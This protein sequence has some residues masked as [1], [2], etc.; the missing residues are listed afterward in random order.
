VNILKGLG[1]E[2]KRRRVLPMTALYI[3]AGWVVVQVASE[4]LPAFNIP[5]NAI[6]YVW[7]A[8]LVG[9]PVAVVFSWR[10]DLTAAGI[11]RTP[12]A[13]ENLKTG[14]R[15][16]KADYGILAALG[17]VMLITVSGVG[18]RLADVQ[19][20]IARAPSTRDIDPNSI[21][22][23]PLENLSPDEDGVYFAS[24]IHDA[25]ITNLSRISALAVTSSTSARRVSP[26]LSVPEI[27]RK[28]GVAKLVEGSVLMEGDR[29]RVIVQLIDAAS[30]LHL[31]AD[32]FERDVTDIMS[33][34][35][36]VARTIADVI[37]VRLT[38]REEKALAQ[39]RPVRPDL[40]RA[41]LKGMYLLRQDTP[42]TDQ[43]AV[44][45]FEEVVREDPDSALAYAGL[46]IGYSNLAHS[47]IPVENAYPKAKTAADFALQLDPELA[48]AHLAVGMYRS[49]YEWDFEG[50]EEAFN[51]AIELNPSLT[52]AHYQLA[53]IYELRGPDWED[54]ALASG[55]RAV[56]LDPL[57][58]F[59]IGGL[60]WQY[61]DACRFE[62]GL[63]VAREAIR[64][65][66]EQPVGWVA[67]GMIY[68]ELGRFDEAID[69]HKKPAEPPWSLFVAMTYAAAGLDD[70]AL[71]FTAA[72]ENVPGA[73]LGLAWIHMNRGDREAAVHWIAAAEKA[74]APWYPWLLGMFHGSETIA[75]DPR[76]QERAAALGLP[77]PRTMGCVA[78]FADA[79][80]FNRVK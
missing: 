43:R 58:A 23:L 62:D 71:E 77:D 52:M 13:G 17:L 66:P 75:D 12:N 5:D 46:A 65:N 51:R 49:M 7:I 34:Q 24:G 68:A 53:W 11:R 69:A 42:E 61:G 47:P 28:L 9:F 50:A 44:E 27:G 18:L 2:L 33:L 37:E 32:T 30:D 22:V 54:R 3:V 16:A 4:M 70:K 80:S 35:N 15:L 76:V 36:D 1:G 78:G 31:W 56:E 48:E 41:Y 19:T 72:L 63:R 38:P 74:R 14:H 57:S 60:A 73:E 79:I 40:Y 8:V 39:A 29:V 59:M 6:G 67:L 26:E 21:A 20:E 25:L 64:V 10:Y 55:E 45:I